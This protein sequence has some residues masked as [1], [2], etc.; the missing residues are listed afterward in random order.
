MK[1]IFS[2]SLTSAE[3]SKIDLDVLRALEGIHMTKEHFP[4][5]YKWKDRVNRF[6][7]EE[8]VK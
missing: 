8:T 5:I 6:R 4:Y 2:V 1:N 7:Q 3:P